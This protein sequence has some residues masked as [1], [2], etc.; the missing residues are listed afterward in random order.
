MIK[1]STAIKLFIIAMGLA[2][3]VLLVGYEKPA[4]QTTPGHAVSKAF[5]PIKR[6]VAACEMPPQPKRARL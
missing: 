1:T 2:A 6:Y 5:T 3:L 4:T